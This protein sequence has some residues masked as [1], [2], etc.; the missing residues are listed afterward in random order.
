M[1]KQTAV[2]WLA[3]HLNADSFI[4]TYVNPEMINR[5]I[6]MEKEQI[7]DAFNAGVNSEDY[8]YPPFELSE[9]D[10]YYN[11]TYKKP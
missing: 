1:P 6:E 5:A 9:S 4:S 2:E 10:Y 11:Q 3:A 7:E 8:F